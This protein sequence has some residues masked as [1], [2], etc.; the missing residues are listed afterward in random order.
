MAAKTAV[1]L[2][3]SD[4]FRPCT[5]GHSLLLD[6][7]EPNYPGCDNTETSTAGIT[8]LHEKDG[9]LKLSVLI[10]RS[11]ML[12]QDWNAELNLGTIPKN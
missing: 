5:V 3:S 4:M 9:L 8:L 6:E 7:V 12:T 10:Q 1:R 11:S 2:K